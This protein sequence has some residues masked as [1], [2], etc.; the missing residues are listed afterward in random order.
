MIWRDRIER[1]PSELDLGIEDFEQR[2]QIPYG[3]MRFNPG[4]ELHSMLV[5]DRA[6]SGAEVAQNRLA[7]V[8]APAVPGVPSAGGVARLA[9]LTLL[10]VLALRLLRRR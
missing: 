7:G 3:R 9:L 4:F 2:M 8:Q 6:L 10:S 1:H 5:Y